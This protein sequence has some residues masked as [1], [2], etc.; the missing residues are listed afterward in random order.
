MRQPRVFTDSDGRLR[1]GWRVAAYMAGFI[2]VIGVIQRSVGTV[3]GAISGVWIVGLVAAIVALPLLLAMTWIFMR[4]IDRRTFRSAGFWWDRTSVPDLLLGL[5]LGAGL[6]GAMCVICLGGGW[7]SLTKVDG[8]GSALKLSLTVIFM[9]V[10]FA[11][12]ALNE[13]II[14]R[15]YVQRTLEEGVGAVYAILI[16]GVMFAIVHALNPGATLLAIVN[17]FLAGVLLGMVYHRFRSIWAVWAMHFAWNFTMA[18]V[19]GVPVSGF[20]TP[21][22]MKLKLTEAVLLETPDWWLVTGGPFGFE[23]GLAST[24]VMVVFI[25]ALAVWK[26]RAA[27]PPEPHP[28][29]VARL[30]DVE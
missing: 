15:G 14:F 21:S 22:V 17:I 26:G 18:P 4:F 13:E 5:L 1:S 16:S 27:R 11:V 12:A 25:S 29:Y 3:M 9:F 30:R 10:G 28:A 8:E 6:V 2:G 7:Y 23:G 19:L 24:G 20:N